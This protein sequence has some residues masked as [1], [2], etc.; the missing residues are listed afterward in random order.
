MAN[1]KLQRY[2]LVAEIISAAAVVVSLIF[3]A[4]QVK[5]NTAAIR[6]STYEGILSDHIEWRM[7]V[8]SSPELALAMLKNANSDSSMSDVERRSADRAWQALWQI[9]E[10]A[11]FA[12][13]YATLGDS[14]W[15]RYEKAICRFAPLTDVET[16]L[17]RYLTPEFV[18]FAK[19]CDP[20]ECI[21]F[22][23]DRCR[24]DH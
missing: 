18:D 19:S 7:T 15:A 4:Y 8:A 5:D 9:Y 21:K 14:E 12:R 23:G 22:Y 2:A 20:S 1:E 17:G 3:V 11:Y 24:K 16:V 6:S 10:R 13:K